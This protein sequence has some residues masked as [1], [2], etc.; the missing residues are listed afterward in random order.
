LKKNLIL[1]TVATFLIVCIYFGYSHYK[2]HR[3]YESYISSQVK[4]SL[5]SVVKTMNHGDKTSDQALTSILESKAISM[6]QL[7]YINTVLYFY[8]EEIQIAREI[9]SQLD[10]AHN[11][12]LHSYIQSSLQKLYPYE[13]Q[14]EKND[15]SIE[16]NSSELKIFKQMKD[17]SSKWKDVLIKYNDIPDTELYDI[18]ESHWINLYNDLSKATKENLN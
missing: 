2:E 11:E 4:H 18:N 1:L 12:H 3:Q 7:N 13:R 10:F 14:L 5:G 16:L 9:A 15:S 17:M 8:I 6:E